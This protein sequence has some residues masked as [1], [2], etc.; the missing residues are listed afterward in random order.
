MNMEKVLLEK[1]MFPMA[2]I[3]VLYVNDKQKDKNYRCF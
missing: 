2:D 3:D 1:I